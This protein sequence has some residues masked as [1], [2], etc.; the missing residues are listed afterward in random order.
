MK[1]L[2]LSFVIF[3]T[4]AGPRVFLFV[5]LLQ[6]LKKLTLLIVQHFCCESRD[7]G[8]RQVWP[9]LFITLAM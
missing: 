3:L 8:L 9:S 7:V 4:S 6:S 2:N 1:N 5:Q